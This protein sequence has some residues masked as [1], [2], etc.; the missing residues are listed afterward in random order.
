MEEVACKKCRMIIKNGSECPICGSSDLTS[1]W[2]GYIIVLNYE[3]S[4]I[5]KNLKININ[6]TFALNIKS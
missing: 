1:K 4:G 2:S 5:A 3:K 6:S